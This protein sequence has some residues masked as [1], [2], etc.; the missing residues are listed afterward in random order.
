VDLS[1]IKEIALQ[2]TS[3]N[4]L[5]VLPGSPE[6]AKRFPLHPKH[7]ERIC[8]GCD[9]YCAASDLQCGNGAGRT[10]HPCEMLGD[11]WYQWGDWGLEDADDP[12]ADD[13]D[14]GKAH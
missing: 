14:A 1:R 13:G 10:L 5:T 8:W 11:D 6:M 7:P 9:K 3:I 2:P 12:T 4:C